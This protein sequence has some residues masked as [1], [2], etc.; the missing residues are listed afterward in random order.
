MDKARAEA[1][2]IFILHIAQKPGLLTLALLLLV[3][4]RVKQ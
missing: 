4:R 3:S 2:T 1:L